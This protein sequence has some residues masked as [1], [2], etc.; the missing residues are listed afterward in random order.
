[1]DENLV[2]TK[3]SKRFID[4]LSKGTNTNEDYERVLQRVITAQKQQEAFLTGS[5]NFGDLIDK[6]LDKFSPGSDDVKLLQS[7]Q[8]LGD[9]R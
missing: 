2:G 7:T 4:E 1:M 8:K 5:K 3:V 9:L 6:K